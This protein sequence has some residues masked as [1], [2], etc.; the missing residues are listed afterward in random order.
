[1]Q[2]LG[3][4]GAALVRPWC[5]EGGN[6]YKKYKPINIFRR[7]HKKPFQ[8]PINRLLDLRPDKLQRK[9]SSFAKKDGQSIRKNHP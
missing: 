8:Y 3:K 7:E 2:A 9:S 6:T 5:E 1:M 4:D